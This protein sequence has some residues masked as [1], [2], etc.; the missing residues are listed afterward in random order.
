MEFLVQ[1]SNNFP[2]LLY[3]KRVLYTILDILSALSDQFDD[4]YDSMS[5]PI[6]LAISCEQIML[7]P[8]SAVRMKIQADLLS[9]LSS[10]FL[11]AIVLAEQELYQVFDMYTADLNKSLKNFNK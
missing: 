5:H 10:M 11:K 1:I 9:L 2:G 6:T 3:K 8:S 4:I 7:D